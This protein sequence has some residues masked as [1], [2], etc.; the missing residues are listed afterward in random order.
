M[1]VHAN[2]A[3]ESAACRQIFAG[4]IFLREKLLPGRHASLETLPRE[5]QTDRPEIFRC[6]MFYYVR[7][8][9][10]IIAHDSERISAAVRIAEHKFF[11][12]D[13]TT[14]T[15]G[16]GRHVRMIIVIVQ[17]NKRCR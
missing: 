17:L 8:H 13:D 3:R 5:R 2:I 1:R 15:G 9:A 4:D 12:L 10:R 6:D 14:T 16:E 7:V 11:S